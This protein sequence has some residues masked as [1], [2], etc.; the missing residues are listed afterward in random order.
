MRVYRYTTEDTEFHGVILFISIMQAEHKLCETLCP[1]WCTNFRLQS[2]KK[3]SQP[4]Y[5]SCP[6]N[7]NK[8]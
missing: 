2:Y 8:T 7:R 1:L 3:D 5:L 6:A 4:V